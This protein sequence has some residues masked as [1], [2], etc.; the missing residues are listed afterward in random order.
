MKQFAVFDVLKR[1]I[2]SID[3]VTMLI[4]CSRDALYKVIQYKL[5]LSPQPSFSFDL[6]DKYHHTCSVIH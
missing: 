4:V 2:D 1:S 5:C 3:F 6:K